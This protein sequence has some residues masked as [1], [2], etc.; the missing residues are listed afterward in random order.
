MEAHARLRQ[1]DP[2]QPGPGPPVRIFRVLSVEEL[3][4]MPIP[5]EASSLGCN[6]SGESLGGTDC[7]G[8]H[9]RRRWRCRSPQDLCRKAA[10]GATV[11]TLI[12]TGDP[13]GV[14]LDTAE[15][16]PADFIVLG[17][18]GLRG[19]DRFLM[20]SV[21]ESVAVHA[22]C[23]VEVI[24]GPGPSRKRPCNGCDHRPTIL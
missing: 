2:S 5:M 16:W 20:G 22:H 9:P 6:L 15:A 18:H 3:V 23:S 10:P 1:R 17:S 19:F 12:P 24:R 13:R 4:T 7:R 21:S 14:I 8:P 11:E